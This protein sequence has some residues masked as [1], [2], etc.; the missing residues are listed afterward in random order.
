MKTIRTILLLTALV[1]VKFGF[2]H[3]LWI[4]AP[5]VG[6]K[7]QSHQVRVYYGEYAQGLI[8]PVEQWYSD[9]KDFKLILVSSGGERT[10]L[11]KTAH[12]DHF[13]SQFTPHTEGTY[14]LIVVH[15]SK[16]PYETTAFEFSSVAQ[17]IVGSPSTQAVDIPIMVQ[18]NAVG[19]FN[20]GDPVKAT[21]TQKGQPLAEMSVEVA[22]PNGWTK[23][24]KTDAQGN[25][26]FQAP[27][28]GKYLVEVS[29]TD[30]QAGDWFGKTIEKVWRAT[31]T[32]LYVD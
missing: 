11:T 12:N 20:I 22:A 8:D 28:K 27:V 4:E 2:S 6:K 31:T 16:D 7:G 17:V 9:V 21:I 29:K 25:I 5:P 3:A 13:S 24:I 1:C 10:E 19:N 26:D 15:P 30:E 23:A 14:S 18:T 32:V